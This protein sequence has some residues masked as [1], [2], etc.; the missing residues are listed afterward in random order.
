MEGKAKQIP[1]KKILNQHLKVDEKG[2]GR[3][4]NTLL[5]EFSIHLKITN[6]MFRSSASLDYL[7][8]SL[9]F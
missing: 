1:T 9:L 4:M 3:E 6:K 5:S 8:K 7:T 2:E